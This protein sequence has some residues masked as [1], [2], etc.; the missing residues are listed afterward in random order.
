MFD[1]NASTRVSNHYPLVASI[2]AH[3]VLIALFWVTPKVLTNQWAGIQ[4]VHAGNIETAAPP[5]MIA[6]RP[7]ARSAVFGESRKPVPPVASRNAHRVM[8]QQSEPDETSIPDD[9]KGWSEIGGAGDVSEQQLQTRLKDLAL[10]RVEPEPVSAPKPPADERTLETSDVSS[11][12]MGGKVEPARLL[13]QVL[14]VYPS[15]ARAARVQ[16]SVV[17]EATIGISGKVENVTVVEGHK[18]LIAAAVDAVRQ[19]QYEPAKLD[20]APT[21]SSVRVTVVFRLEFPH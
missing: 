15:L 13:K 11:I 12:R 2:T 4:I 21:P 5:T 6:L 7:P 14:P 16:G 1:N 8:F 17:L 10:M 19:W 20:D 18:M 9:L 3:A